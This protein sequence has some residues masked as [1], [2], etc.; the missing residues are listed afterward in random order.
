[1]R[2]LGIKLGVI[3]LVMMMAMV[4]A[5]CE[6]PAGPQGNVGGPGQDASVPEIGSSGYWYLDGASLGI[7]AIPVIT[8]SPY[9]GYWYLGGVTTGVRGE[10]H[11][12]P[13]VTICDDTDEW[14]IDG[15]PTGVIARRQEVTIGSN[16]N[17]FIDGEDTGR[18]AE[19]TH[20]TGID[21]TATGGVLATVTPNRSFTLSMELGAT[22][23]LTANVV[24]DHAL[25]QTLIWDSSDTNVAGIRR[26]NRAVWT[27][28]ATAL[29]IEALT[30]GQSTVEV[31][32]FGSGQTEVTTTITVIVTAPLGPEGLVMYGNANNS[33]TISWDAVP[34]ATG[35]EIRFSPGMDVASATPFTHVGTGTTATVTGLTMETIYS[36]WV[37]ALF[38]DEYSGW[39]HVTT[40]TLPF[41]QAYDIIVV[42]AGAAGAAA[43]IGA[44]SVGFEHIVG[45]TFGAE[46][47]MLNPAA[48]NDLSVLILEK[49]PVWGGMTS[50]A[51]AGNANPGNPAQ[52]QADA[53]PFAGWRNFYLTTL[54]GTVTAD[55]SPTFVPLPENY[56]NWS[57][58][59]AI[60]RQVRETNNWLR[61]RGSSNAVGGIG[62]SN[63]KFNRIQ[64]N[65]IAEVRLNEQ[66]MS[67]ILNPDG[68]VIG[69]VSNE[70]EGSVNPNFGTQGQHIILG[71]PSGTDIR[72]AARRV[73]LATGG[74]S[75]M[76]IDQQLSSGIIAARPEASFFNPA[77]ANSYGTGIVMAQ[78][79]GAAV[80]GNWGALSGMMNVV[81]YQFFHY[82][83]IMAYPPRGNG[84]RSNWG[85]FFASHIDSA[86][87]MKS[88]MMRNQQIVVSGQTGLRIRPEGALTGNAAVHH[89]MV[90]NAPVWMLFS[91]VDTSTVTAAVPPGADP[92]PAGPS[93]AWTRMEVL[94]TVY[95]YIN[96]LPAGTRQN[97]LRRDI[98]RGDSLPELGVELGLSPAAIDALVAEVTYYDTR[99]RRA[100]LA[101]D[102]A[103]FLAWADPLTVSTH[104]NHVPGLAGKPA[105][106]SNVRFLCDDD[107]YDIVFFAVR[108]YHGVWD[109]MGG[110]AADMW[111]RVLRYNL[112][113]AGS[114]AALGLFDVNAIVPF[115]SDDIIRNLYAAGAVAARD[116]YTYAYQSL[117]SLGIGMTQGAL[118]GQHAARSIL[119]IQHRL[120]TPIPGVGPSSPVFYDPVSG[121]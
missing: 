20:V 53:F 21:I 36:V 60:F 80:T 7:R 89:L 35:Y 25:V 37:R 115:D 98:R 104:P 9:T 101:A 28:P 13:E 87:S 65:N 116:L 117:S 77:N 102:H 33:V 8:L 17:W 46:A 72:I 54:G 85:R 3:A 107:G 93:G 91:A 75:N 68:D 62:Q 61:R 48:W 97:N 67:L 49:R 22:A 114:G 55:P 113:T 118:A 106:D 83:H 56:P 41:T 1:M 92:F 95:E 70:V 81:G 27:G 32:A 14:L 109:S 79:A 12:A 45:A 99:V 10:A 120:A 15:A 29:E 44:R 4:F 84:P 74:F 82:P 18:R 88:P 52:I 112:P 100:L 38:N 110:L 90:R 86:F 59:Y 105:G 108:L 5:G 103:D 43:A 24:P 19:V 42:G 66:A 69:V 64:N 40:A 63:T 26:V 50:F 31:T 16:G 58:Q 6:G 11:E 121:Q 78:E 73:I 111:G 76:P 47:P 57:R 39:S 96:A 30:L 94:E 23:T 51:T 71:D 34:G 2:K 119:G